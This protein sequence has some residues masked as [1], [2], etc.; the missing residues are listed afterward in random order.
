MGDE[1]PLRV[2]HVGAKASP[3]TVNGDNQ[4]AWALARVQALQGHEVTMVVIEDVPLADHVDVVAGDAAAA[5]E[6]PALTAGQIRLTTFKDAIRSLARNR[7]DVVHLHSVNSPAQALLALRAR[8][9]S[10]PYVITPHGGYAPQVLARHDARKR[11]YRS[12]IERWKV[13]GAAAAAVVVPAEADD[14]A[15]IA[16]R[17]V[18][19]AVIPNIVDAIRPCADAPLAD[20]SFEHDVVYLGRLDVIPKGLDHVVGIA[21]ALPH[22]SFD[23]YGPPHPSVDGLDLPPNVT[24]HEP[25]Y[26]AEKEHVL[27][28]ARVLVQLSRWEVFGVSVVESML[29][30]LQVLV[31]DVMRLSPWVRDAGGLVVAGGDVPEAARV[32]EEFLS[33]PHDQAAA[34]ARAAAAGR[35]VDPIANELRYRDLYRRVIAASTPKH[36]E[37]VPR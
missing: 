29:L 36:A 13:R 16:G 6:A 10:V 8:T 4:A 5:G 27:R 2:W 30:G 34:N 11:L 17:H 25:V 33:A 35:L 21:R 7:V 23:L 22:R 20:R 28:S 24:L 37:A 1:A 32:L 14:V 9:R 15:R 31:A 18:D 26:G 3:R 19:C 12:T